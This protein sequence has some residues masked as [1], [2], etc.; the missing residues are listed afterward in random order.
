ME[1]ELKE[2]NQRIKAIFAVF[3]WFKT[4]FLQ[5]RFFAKFLLEVG[6]E[7][8]HTT[9]FHIRTDNGFFLKLLFIFLKF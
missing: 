5:D 6:E 3:W 7:E 2:R 4:F 8:L 1:L 9:C